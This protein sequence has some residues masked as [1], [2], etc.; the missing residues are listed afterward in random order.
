MLKQIIIE[1]LLIVL[2]ALPFVIV[3]FLVGILLL[4]MVF[5]PM[6]RGGG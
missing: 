3:G 6:F 2:F 5:G 1:G 4:E